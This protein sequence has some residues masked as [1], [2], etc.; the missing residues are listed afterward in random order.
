MLDIYASQEISTKLRDKNSL[1]FLA[2]NLRNPILRDLRVRQ[3]LA[4]GIDKEELSSNVIQNGFSIPANTLFHPCEQQFS[5]IVKFY[6]YDPSQSRKLLG[7]AKWNS[8]K[9]EPILR[10]FK[11][12]FELEILIEDTAEK[13]RLANKIGNMWQKFGI[14]TKIK[15]LDRTSY[16]SALT[17]RDFSGVAIAHVNLEVSR[18]FDTIFSKNAIPSRQNNSHGQ[19]IF[20][21]HNEKINTILAQLTN[22]WNPTNHRNLLGSCKSILWKTFLQFHF[23]IFLNKVLSSMEI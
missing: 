12:K 16:L 10:K 6:P 18:S 8:Y 14:T 13:V 2:L 23:Y 21:W 20:G 11:R 22:N 17:K 19:N 15:A 4:F 1:E 7:Q 9:Q 5:N 3:A